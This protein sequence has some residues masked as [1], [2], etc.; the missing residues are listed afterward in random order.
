MIDKNEPEPI[1]LCGLEQITKAM[2]LPSRS[3]LIKQLKN[4]PGFPIMKF[5]EDGSWY[6]T[7]AALSEWVENRLKVK[8][9]S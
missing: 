7:R 1:L 9:G 6:S 5:E 3:R 8:R 2:G 4:E